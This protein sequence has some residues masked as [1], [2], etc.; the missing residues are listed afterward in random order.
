MY[1]T[2]STTISIL[3]MISIEINAMEISSQLQLP[4]LN[5]QQQKKE[6]NGNIQNLLIHPSKFAFSEF[7]LLY[8]S[9][10][11]VLQMYTYFKKSY[12]N[13]DLLVFLE[14][15]YFQLQSNIVLGLDEEFIFYPFFRNH[16][17][18]SLYLK[19]T[20]TPIK[21]KIVSYPYP[22]SDDILA[23]LPSNKIIPFQF[24]TLNSPVMLAKNPE[25]SDFFVAL[26]KANGEF[27]VAA[28]GDAHGIDIS[29][30]LHLIWEEV[31]TTNTKICEILY[32]KFTHRVTIP[33]LRY[34]RFCEVCYTN[35][36]KK[37]KRCV[38][39][40]FIFRN[41]FKFFGFI[42]FMLPFLSVS[43]LIAYW[44]CTSFYN[45]QALVIMGIHSYIYTALIRAE[46]LPL[47][48]FTIVTW[49]FIINVEESCEDGFNS[50]NPEQLNI[51]A[52]K[53]QKLMWKFPI[54]MQKK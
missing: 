19:K 2:L 47:F 27:S 48:F 18:H 41:F 42:I 26:S 9:P 31:Y 3:I 23:L 7:I 46:I 28:Y 6:F 13:L 1:R 10:E 14:Q 33:Y 43:F 4:L 24:P 36:Y 20:K 35:L 45:P 38:E 34:L 53:P 39:L 50:L 51:F 11:G 21:F 54:L 29:Q 40:N 5:K 12:S 49:R 32:L 17:S 30:N 16:T 25:G 44:T 52:I 15:Y 37:F 8:L 22:H